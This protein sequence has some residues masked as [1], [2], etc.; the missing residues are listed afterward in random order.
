MIRCLLLLSLAVLTIGCNTGSERSSAAEAPPDPQA[1]ALHAELFAAADKGDVVAFRTLLTPRSVGL[2][3][4]F[5]RAAEG[6]EGSPDA[7]ALWKELLTHHAELSSAARARAPYP[8]VDGKLNLAGHADA[9][10]FEAA[11]QAAGKLKEGL[12]ER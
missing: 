6:L 11:A 2:L 4:G 9:G 3:D 1:L 5:F 8:V 10:F 12:A 7:R